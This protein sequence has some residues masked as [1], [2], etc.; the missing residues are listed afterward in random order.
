MP[1]FFDSE[2]EPPPPRSAA[3]YDNVVVPLPA[4]DPERPV[5]WV[6]KGGWDESG[7]AQRPWVAPGYLMRGAVTVLAG[8]GSAG[9][10]SIAKAWAM[11]AT[12]GEDFSRIR[13]ANPMRVLTYNTEDDLAEEQRR[14]GAAL[15]QFNRAAAEIPQTFI[16]AGPQQVGTLIERD[17][18][19][20]YVVNTAAMRQL[21]AVMTEAQPD[22]VILDPLV[23]L[24]NA[25]ENDN[26]G[27]RAVIAEFRT[28]AQRFN[29]AI[30]IL[31]HTR[32]GATV[33]GD[34]DS[35]RGASAI[36][37][38][39]R[40][41][42]TCVPMS[43][44]EA[45]KLGIDPKHRRW[46]FRVDSAKQNYAPIEDA[47]WFR[48]TLYTLDNGEEIVAAEPWA[49][50]SPWDGLSWDV[51]D[52]II[53]HIRSVPS[54]GEMYAAAKQSKARWVGNLVMDLGCRSEAQANSIIRS[55]I[56]NGLLVQTSYASPA[57]KHGETAGLSVNETKFAEM[58]RSG[59]LGNG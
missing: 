22:I 2:G 36:V 10:S 39:A 27:L 4:P 12:F 43:E 24:H 6:S 45:A 9:K 52:Q 29:C 13:F 41:V 19:S 59:D 3:D 42:M 57:R 21:V 33:P 11:A 16:I 40:V 1:N 35:L 23:E 17:P 28:L 47:E 8:P 46:Y 20:G 44:D 38:A 50:P 56:E 37:G 5:L 54:S 55:W 14:I 7:I 18:M 25:E 15:R 26:T 49:P 51:I 30:L 34:P 32:K 53:D 48:R 58:R 31:H